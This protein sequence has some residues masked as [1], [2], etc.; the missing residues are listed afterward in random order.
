M[1]G[2]EGGADILWLETFSDL[3][4]L[5]IATEEAQRAADL[6]VVTSLTF[7]E[8]LSLLDGT[9]PDAAA[10]VLLA[11]GVDVVGV[12]CGVGPEAC[13]DALERTGKPTLETSRSIL[14]NAGLPAA[15]GA[16]SDVHQGRVRG[17]PDQ[18]PADEMLVGS[19][20]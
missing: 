20:V 9:T 15:S 17:F 8:E 5:L 6:P 3:E 13:L 18:G 2:T 4:T 11:A 14:P 12:N 19:R 7:G 16:G 1:I 10:G